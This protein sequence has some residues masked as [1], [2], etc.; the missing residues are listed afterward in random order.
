MQIERA[1]SGI[2]TLGPGSRLVVWVN[3]C[4]RRC[5]GCVSERLRK[6]EPRNERDIM[7]F[8]SGFDFGTA[9]GVTISGGEPFEQPAELLKFVRFV[10]SKGLEDILIYTGYTIEE[11]HARHDADTD[12]VLSEIAVL[13]DGPYMQEQ[14]KDIGNLKGSDNQRVIFLKDKFIPLYGAFYCETRN[15]Q[16]LRIG[17]YVVAAGIPTREYIAQFTCDTNKTGRK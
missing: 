9:D 11:L 13:I 8:F 7:Q 1:I 16:E 4:N 14:N 15:M 17:N 3:G 5:K 6:F 12:G 10:K 2:T